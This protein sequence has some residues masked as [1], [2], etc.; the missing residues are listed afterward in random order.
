MNAGGIGKLARGAL[1]I[2]LVGDGFLF[3]FVLQDDEEVQRR[4]WNG[5]Q[6]C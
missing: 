4:V 2:E 3:R 1:T 6:Y 5:R